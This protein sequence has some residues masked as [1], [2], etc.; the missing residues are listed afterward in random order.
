MSVIAELIKNPCAGRMG[1]SQAIAIRKYVANARRAPRA[2]IYEFLK[3]LKRSGP[4]PLTEKFNADSI[5]WLQRLFL[6]KDGSPR[7]T[8]MARRLSDHQ[9][10]V[11]Q[12]STGFLLVGAV[13]MIDD[14]ELANRPG[15]E[16][17]KAYVVWRATS[18]H[19]AWFDYYV[20]PWQD[21]VDS[22]KTGLFVTNSSDLYEGDL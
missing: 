16:K 8:G 9:M 10:R 7:K 11:V 3:T 18:S 2:P 12:N 15:C 5:V 6:R 14:W 17:A 4:F 21:N 19:G 13:A 20:V 1:K 22:T